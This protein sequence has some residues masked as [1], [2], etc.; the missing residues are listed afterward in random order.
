[1]MQSL[2]VKLDALA[3]FHFTP[4]PVKLVLFFSV[5]VATLALCL[6]ACAC[7]RVFRN[8]GYFDVLFFTLNV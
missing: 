4:K 1:M 3:N 6:F 5:L 8:E 7:S 2:F